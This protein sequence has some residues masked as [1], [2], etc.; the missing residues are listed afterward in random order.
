MTWLPSLAACVL[1]RAPGH[2]I[3]R[4]HPYNIYYTE[5]MSGSVETH[6]ARTPQ[7]TLNLRQR[8]IRPQSMLGDDVEAIRMDQN[9]GSI[10]ELP[11]RQLHVQTVLGQPAS[12]S[13]P[14]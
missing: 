12:A 13:L 3:R 7:A 5:T 14:Q 4:A 9:G 2:V 11:Y 1:L 10:R 8:Q 6:A